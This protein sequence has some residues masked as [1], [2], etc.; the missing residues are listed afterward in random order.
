M[1][2]EVSSIWASGVTDFE[3]KGITTHEATK[4]ILNFYCNGA[5]ISYILVPFNNLLEVILAS[6]ECIRIEQTTHGLPHYKGL[7]NMHYEK[8]QSK[9]DTW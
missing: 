9:E 4:G 5:G 3:A 1:F 6:T 8:G 7:L 2:T